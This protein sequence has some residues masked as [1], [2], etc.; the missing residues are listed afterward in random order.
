MNL[1]SVL[2]NYAAAS[3]ISREIFLNVFLNHFKALEKR[4]PQ[5]GSSWVL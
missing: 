3:S 5:K 4:V 2:E 1:E